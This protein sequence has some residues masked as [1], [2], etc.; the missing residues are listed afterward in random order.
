VSKRLIQCEA[1]PSARV[2]FFFHIAQAW[3]CFN[4][5]NAFLVNKLFVLA[6]CNLKLVMHMTNSA[7]FSNSAVWKKIALLLVIFHGVI[8]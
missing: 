5:F 6:T 3:Q 1:K 7:V 8:S 4:W 2:L